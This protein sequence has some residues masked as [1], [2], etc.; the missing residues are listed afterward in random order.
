MKNQLGIWVWTVLVSSFFLGSNLFASISFDAEQISESVSATATQASSSTQTAPSDLNSRVKSWEMEREQKT[1]ELKPEKIS[2]LEKFLMG[3]NESGLGFNWHGLYPKFGGIDS[4]GGSGLAAGLR[5]WRREMFGSPMDLQA[6]FLYS[7]RQYHVG[8]IQFGKIMRYD[9]NRLMGLRGYGG[10]N[11][12][13]GLDR[14]DHR[15]FLFGTWR[16]RDFGEEDFFGIGPNSLVDNATDYRQKDNTLYGTIGYRLT[17]WSLVAGSG[18]YMK[19]EIEPGRDSS[20]PNTEIE[21]S[22]Q[23]APG[24][25]DDTDFIYGGGAFVI[26][27]RDRPYNPHS[28]FMFGFEHYKYT[29]NNDTNFSFSRTSYDLRGYIP[30][31]AE[32]RTLAL[33][34]YTS[35][36]D[37]DSGNR[38][39]FYL[40]E[41]LGGPDSLRGFDRMRFRD[42]NLTSMSAEY[43]WEPS[44]YWELALFYDAGKV[45][46]QTT[47]WNFNDLETGYGFGVRFKLPRSVLIRFDIGRSSDEGTHFYFRFASPSF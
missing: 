43:R 31:F 38:V 5:Y 40:M 45:F 46:P 35:L 37:P 36:N 2:R 13:R 23:T 47:N 30:V 33:Q 29:D 41:T 21:F 32:H 42:E 7:I 11:N 27:F 39:P 19:V 20:L 34:L 8:G 22:D 6:T 12:F 3:Y 15:F 10:L 9:V 4:A 44:P 25:L 1:K 24:L 28:G 26:D 17:S 14:K 16:L 18:G